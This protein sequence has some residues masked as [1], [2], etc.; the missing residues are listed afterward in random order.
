LLVAAPEALDV[1][2]AL[3]DQANIV[4]STQRAMLDGRIDA[5]GGKCL[6]GIG[7]C[8][9]LQVDGARGRQYRRRVGPSASG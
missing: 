2:Y 6:A 8:L 9:V 4:Q 1:H 3:Q 5:E 7:D